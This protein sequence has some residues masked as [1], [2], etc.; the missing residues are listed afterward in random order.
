[1]VAACPISSFA[2]QLKVD[3]FAAGLKWFNKASIV[4]SS[5]TVILGGGSFSGTEIEELNLDDARD[6]GKLLGLTRRQLWYYITEYV[7]EGIWNPRSPSRAK[8]QF[9]KLSVN[10]LDWSRVIG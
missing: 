4:S 8:P 9:R 6:R 1:V 7:M 5:V 2:K 3:A 10:I